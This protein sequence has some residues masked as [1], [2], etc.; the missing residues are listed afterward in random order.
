MRFPRFRFTSDDQLPNRGLI[1]ITGSYQLLML[2]LL[3]LN[4]GYVENLAWWLVFHSVVLCYL[5]FKGTPAWEENKLWSP[6][7]IIPLNF[8]ELHYLVHLVNLRSIDVFIGQ[9]DRYVLG[10]T[11]SICLCR[12]L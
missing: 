3:F 6:L 11:P 12:R 10:V 7:L 8:T 4:I 1:L 9:L 2:L 5:F